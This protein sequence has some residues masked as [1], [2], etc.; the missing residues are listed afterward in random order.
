MNISKTKGIVLKGE[1]FRDSSRIFT[2][3]SQKSGKL[4]LLAKGVK[5]PKS[6]MAGN[7][8]QFSVV[9]IV[10]YKKQES[11][12]HL[13]SQAELLEPHSKIY[14]NLTRLSFA[15]AML[16]LVERLTVEE[17]TH[18]GLFSLLSGSLEK[19]ENLPP[20]K[21]PILL[22]SFA[23]RLSA[24]LGYRPN[25]AG[26]LHCKKKTSA[27]PY[28][29]FCVEQGGI[30]CKGC[31]QPGMFYLKLSPQSWEVM[32]RMLAVSESEMEQIEANPTQLKEISEVILNL[33]EY[34][35]HTRKGLKSLEFLEKV[36]V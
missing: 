33:L 24:N 30:V 25:L 34:H 10:F 26:C 3:F 2:I 28:I 19:I 21:L 22:W 11:S 12:L 15:S 6:R 1:N 9:E 7:L 29:L 27:G 13:L 32:K 23:L 20:E 31:A 18:P 4:R 17:E 16:E 36:K 35:A 8:Q 14:G 5:N